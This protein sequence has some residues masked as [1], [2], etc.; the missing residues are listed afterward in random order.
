ML[1]KWFSDRQTACKIISVGSMRFD[2]HIIALKIFQICADNAIHLEIQW[3]PRTEIEKADFIS[4]IIDIDDWQITRDC[5][6]AIERLWGIHT[7][8]CFANYYNKK[9]SKYFSRFWNPGSSGVDFFVQNIKGENCLVVPASRPNCK[10]TSLF[11]CMQSNGHCNCTILAFI[12]ILA[13]TFKK[14][15]EF[16]SRLSVLQRKTFFSP[17]QKYQFVI[18]FQ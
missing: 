2:L 11:V 5:F 13:H 18:G 3:I 4:R 10:G 17:W 12:P 6:E 1:I 7:V 14:I 15:C 16:R 8:D 9:V